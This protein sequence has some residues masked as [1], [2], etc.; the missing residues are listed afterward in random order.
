MICL[1]ASDNERFH[2]KDSVRII[3]HPNAYHGAHL[4]DQDIEISE[5]ISKQVAGKLDSAL[6]LHDHPRALTVGTREWG[7][8]THPPKIHFIPCFAKGNCN[9]DVHDPSLL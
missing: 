1:V 9:F 5:L 7:S 2:V 3:D 6:L 4:F 8:A